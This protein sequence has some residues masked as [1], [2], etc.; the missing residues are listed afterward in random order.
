M[1]LVGHDEID[2]GA[3]FATG[4]APMIDRCSTPL[5]F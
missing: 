1:A 4:E 2:I 5:Y 3:L